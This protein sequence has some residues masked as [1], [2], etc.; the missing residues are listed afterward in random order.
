MNAARFV[1]LMPSPHSKNTIKIKRTPFRLGH[2]KI[3]ALLQ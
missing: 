3:L 1:F 2:A